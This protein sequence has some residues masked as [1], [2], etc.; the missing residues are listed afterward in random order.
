MNA[1]KGDLEELDAFSAVIKPMPL[2]Q[3][4]DGIQELNSIRRHLTTACSL[5]TFPAPFLRQYR[6][7][8]ETCLV[9]CFT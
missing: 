9:K 7:L 6:V 2:P 5:S 8:T 1:P 4:L 3:I